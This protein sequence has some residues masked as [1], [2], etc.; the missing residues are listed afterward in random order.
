MLTGRGPDALFNLGLKRG[1]MRKFLVTAGLLAAVAAPM[2]AQN[3]GEPVTSGQSS[4]YLSPYVGYIWYGDL[5]EFPDDVEYSNDNG[6]NYGVQ[7][8]VSFSPNISLI[9]NFGYNKSKF[10]LESDRTGDDIDASGDLGI[11][12]YDANLQFRVPFIANRM[13]SW[14]APV[15]QVGVGAMKYTAD[16]D[17][18][19]SDGETNVA[20]NVGLGADFQ[21]MKALGARIMIKDYITSLAWSDADQV[22]FDDDIADNVAHNW[23]L[24]FGLNFGF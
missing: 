1:I 13:G 4:F 17:D 23:A 12:F 10:T 9:G 15:M 18:F 22:D 20:F 8:G 3:P 16:T 14:L 11:F 19:N 21:L 2:Q 6:V 7:A 24:T 5:F